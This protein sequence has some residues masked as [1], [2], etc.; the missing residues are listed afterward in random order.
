VTEAIFLQVR[1][2][3][4][5][6]SRKAL[7]PLAGVPV[8]VHAMRA[9]R[10]VPVDAYVLLTDEVGAHELSA[11]A[12]REAFQVFAGDPEDV[13]ARFCAAAEHYAVDRIVR[14]TGDNPL[15]S[16]SMAHAAL[17]LSRNTA[18]DYAGITD[19]P[20]GSGVEVL[21]SAALLSAHRQ[22]TD[23]YCREHVS[24]FLQNNPSRFNVVRR[25]APRRYRRPE[26]RVTLDTPED[27]RNLAH[28]FLNL[29]H[30]RPIE[31]DELI[32]YVEGHRN[33]V[34]A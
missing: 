23:R 14:A 7:L 3:S 33:Q 30:S 27:Y 31:L 24:P 34:S 9:L 19:L 5:R 25:T 28:L 4:T 15:V 1:L 8:I 22:T 29:Y 32:A 18:A 6:L 20:Y 13:L 2:E 11:P 17:D 21:S 12:R 10:Q 26:I 16:P